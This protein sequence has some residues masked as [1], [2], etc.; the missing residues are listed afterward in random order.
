MLLK[1]EENV[2]QD[3]TTNFDSIHDLFPP[4]YVVLREILVSFPVHFLKLQR[5]VEN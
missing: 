1:V 4:W 3:A 2:V 5:G